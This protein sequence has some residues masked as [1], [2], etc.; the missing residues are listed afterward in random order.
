MNQ[1]FGGGMR[2]LRRR[3]KSEKTDCEHL[4]LVH[5]DTPGQFPVILLP[6]ICA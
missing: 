5:L 2:M 3:R 1:V 4:D 6:V